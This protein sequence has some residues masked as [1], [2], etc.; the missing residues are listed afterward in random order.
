MTGCRPGP[1]GGFLEGHVPCW[2]HREG[3][4]VSGSR[5]ALSHAGSCSGDPG[6]WPGGCRELPAGSEELGA[7]QG[8]ARGPGLTGGSWGRGVRPG[9]QAWRAGLGLTG[10]GEGR[11]QGQ[12]EG[13]AAHGSRGTSL[14]QP[15]GSP[16]ALQDALPAHSP[17][18]RLNTA[19]GSLG[20]PPLST[21]TPLLPWGQRVVRNTWV[22]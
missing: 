8:E 19:L 20:G 10:L 16:P 2:G 9:V 22:N 13:R 15:T 5:G 17:L 3:E 18:P 21:P 1:W 7:A 11:A 6:L 14:T 4:K 12:G